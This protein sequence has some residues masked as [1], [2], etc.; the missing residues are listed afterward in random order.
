MLDIKWIEKA[1]VALGVTLPSSY[2]ANM[3]RRNG[4]EVQL[5][6]E[7]WWLYPV[8]DS[9]DRNSIRRTAGDIL[10]ATQ[11]AVSDGLGFPT[12]GV[13]IA[14][15]GASDLLFLRETQGT[16]GHAV[17]VFRLRGGELALAV[18]D[19]AHLWP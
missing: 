4:G 18:D 7:S 5:D 14:H 17:W 15:N 16:L 1:E 8:R 10:R 2:V 19:V 3:R 13:A 11:T 12:G 9:T 6:G